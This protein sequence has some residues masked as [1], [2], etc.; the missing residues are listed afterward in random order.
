MEE[1]KSCYSMSDLVMNELMECI[2]SDILTSYSTV[3]LFISFTCT[4][5]N[6]NTCRFNPREKKETDRFRRVNE[7]IGSLYTRPPVQLKKKRYLWHV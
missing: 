3:S 6:Y 7:W 1:N 4:F 5:F 2:I